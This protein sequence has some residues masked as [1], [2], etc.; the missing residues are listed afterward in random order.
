[1][2]LNK[3]FIIL[4]AF[5]LILSWI[6]NVSSYEK[7]ILKEPVF[8]KNYSDVPNVLNNLRLQYIENI[9]SETRI[10]S[11]DF[12]EIEQASVSFTDT[13]WNNDGRYYVLRNIDI[14][15]Y[16]GDMSNIPDN[17]KN[18]VITKAKVAFT[19]GK[20]INVDIGKIYLYSDTTDK[21]P[22]VTEKSSSSNNNTGY[23]ILRAS[24]DTQVTGI[25]S[26]FPEFVEDIL[27]MEVNGKSIKETKFPFGL[28]TGDTL[29]ISYKIN[30]NDNDIRKN[31]KYNFII[32][33]LTKDSDG[34]KGKG[35]C[36]F[37]YWLQSP[38]D[39]DIQAIRTDRR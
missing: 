36:F 38:K 14:K 2:N 17:L 24:K 7:H 25:D 19:D 12:P 5:L 28:K 22:L 27:S 31:C 15:L 13:D 11:I 26:R 29:E 1:M 9:N 18:K 21:Y 37:D 3:K 20:V 10:A 4:G 23:Y 35:I 30:F 39:Y 8:I 16:N 32:N 34:A 6:W 33:V